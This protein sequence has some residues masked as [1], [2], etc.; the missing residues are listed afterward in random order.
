M[1]LLV[2][3]IH[4]VAP[5]TLEE[6]ETWR[7][8]VPRY[9]GR[10][11]WRAGADRAWARRR[12]D[13]G[14]ELVLH[15]YSH[16]RPGGRHGAELAGRSDHEVRASI[17]EGLEELRAAGLD[18]AGFIAPAY[19]HP[20]AADAICRAAGLGWWATRASLRWEG[21]RRS[22]PSLGLGVSTGPRRALSP[23]IARA[24]A[25]ALERVAVVRLD[26]HPADLR[27]RRLARAGRELLARLL[28]QGRRPVTHEGVSQTPPSERLLGGLPRRR[29]WRPWVHC[30][31]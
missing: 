20:P 21:G 27:H 15:G 3:S 31:S 4:D 13:A 29:P 30:R 10:D 5:S 18:P 19:A 26:L 22:L 11:S 24:S 28:D 6:S 16:L 7:G 8:L 25:R 1:K 17:V 9:E 2:V 14:D 12:A 23:A